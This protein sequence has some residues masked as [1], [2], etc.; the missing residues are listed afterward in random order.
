VTKA[1]P[2]TDAEL[3]KLKACS[4]TFSDKSY[5]FVEM[6]RGG[7]PIAYIAKFS[8]SLSGSW[9]TTEALYDELSAASPEY[10]S[11]KASD[12]RD[13]ETCRCAN[14]QLL[15]RYN[16]Y[17]SHGAEELAL[18]G[19][20][21]LLPAG[22]ST[23]ATFYEHVMEDSVVR[24]GEVGVNMPAYVGPAMLFYQEGAQPDGSVMRITYWL[25]DSIQVPL[26]IN[27]TVSYKDG[28]TKEFSLEL[29]P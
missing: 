4:G 24:V 13:K 14:R 18:G 7:A 26:R 8:G 1:E 9:I 2:V 25:A 21:G 29:L 22:L 5:R 6:E 19:E 23:L 20:C 11:I 15:I 3:M 27:G 12:Y 17:G 10:Y 16:A 28:R